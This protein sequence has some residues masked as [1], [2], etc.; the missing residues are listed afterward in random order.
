MDPAY[1]IGMLLGFVIANYFNYVDQAKFHLI[2]P[3][4]FLVIFSQIPESPQHLINTQRHKVR[5][6]TN[7]TPYFHSNHEMNMHPQAANKA[8]KFFKGTE[9]EK[10]PVNEAKDIEENSELSFSDFSK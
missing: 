6:L 10:L 3:A 1:N 4:I 8:H 2:L 9:L 7:V 5:V